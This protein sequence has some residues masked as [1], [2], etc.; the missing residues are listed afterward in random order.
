[1]TTKEIHENK[2]E[3]FA[4]DS[5]SYANVKMCVELMQRKDSR[6]DDSQAYR[7]KTSTID[8]LMLFTG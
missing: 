3:Q 4:V 1:M 2:V 7:P 6:D 8:K 5:S